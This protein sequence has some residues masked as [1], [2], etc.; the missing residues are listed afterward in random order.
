[1]DQIIIRKIERETIGKRGERRKG[2]KKKKE[3]EKGRN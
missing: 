2:R 3:E 1:M